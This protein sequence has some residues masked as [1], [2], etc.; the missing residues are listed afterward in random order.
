M[1]K[2]LRNAIIGSSLLMLGSFAHAQNYQQPS[3]YDQQYSNNVVEQVRADL[4][5]TLNM[6]YLSGSQRSVLEQASSDLGIFNQDWNRG[7]F[8][9]HEID[10]AIARIQSVASS[11]RITEE[12]RAMLLD[13][14]NRLRNFR[15]SQVGGG[16]NG[17]YRDNGY[18]RSNGF[19]DRSNGYYDRYGNWHPYR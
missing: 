12:Q 5:E 1:M 3:E 15:T 8:N 10:E 6:G 14:M 7:R 9:R 17:Y 18:Y 11:N 13:D 2:F 4:N 16:Y 19:Y